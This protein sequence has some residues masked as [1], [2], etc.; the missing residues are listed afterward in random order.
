M[1]LQPVLECIVHPCLPASARSTKSGKNLLID[2][3][4][5]LFFAATAYRPPDTMTGGHLLQCHRRIGRFIVRQWIYIC[6]LLA[7]QANPI[8]LRL[9][10]SAARAHLLGCHRRCFQAI[11]GKPFFLIG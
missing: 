1:R 10:T 2:T 9:T 8:S 7:L 5:N 6:R 3:D 4:R 11:H